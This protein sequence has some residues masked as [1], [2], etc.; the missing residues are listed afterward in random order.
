MKI[1]FLCLALM[2]IAL[3]LMTAPPTFARI[4]DPIFGMSWRPDE[5][6]TPYE[7]ICGNAYEGVAWASN[8]AIDWATNFSGCGDSVCLFESYVATMQAH[9]TEMWMYS[10]LQNSSEGVEWIMQLKEQFI[11]EQANIYGVSYGGGCYAC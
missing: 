8:Y 4:N 11:A 6:F 7:W 5:C 10:I 1:Q 9:F 3:V 2:V